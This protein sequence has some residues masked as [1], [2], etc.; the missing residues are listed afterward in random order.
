MRT[1]R[2]FNTIVSLIVVGL[3]LAIV[4]LWRG[5]FAALERDRL[6]RLDD[7]GA[8]KF[9]ELPTR[10]SSTPTIAPTTT[11]R[12]TDKKSTAIDATKPKSL[13]TAVSPLTGTLELGENDI[14][15]DVPYTSQ[16]PERI[17]TQPWQDACEE[18]AILMLD[19][20]YRGYGLST[21]YAKDELQK[22]VNWEEAR[23]W[24]RS[25]P[26]EKIKIILQE[27]YKIT[28]P[29]RIISNPT[30]ADIKSLIAAGKPVLAVA[31]GHAL[32][33][34]YYSNGGPPYH[35]FIIRGYTAD[36]FIANDPGVNRGKDFVFPIESVMDSLHDWNDG[37]V[38]RGTPAILVID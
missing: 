17:W 12:P 20:Y 3:I 6:M 24:E 9:L 31:D 21:L 10:V 30:V 15:L 13:R 35:A 27:Y 16:A 8:L 5:H 33:N 2:V 34:P 19:A 25:I 11:T 36:K 32:P 1:H 26:I 7:E 37:N 4:W 14:N 28:R 22:V 18:A 23:G 38:T 29:I